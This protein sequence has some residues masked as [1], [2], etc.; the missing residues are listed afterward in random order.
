MAASS[1]RGKATRSS[2][3][4]GKKRTGKASKPIVSLS[5][6][7]RELDARHRLGFNDRPTDVAL[8]RSLAS[9]LDRQRK[10]GD[11]INANLVRQ[12][13]DALESLRESELTRPHDDDGPTDGTD[14]DADD[15]D[16]DGPAAA[17]V[18]L[19]RWRVQGAASLGDAFAAVAPVEPPAVS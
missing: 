10:A 18:G 17:V 4:D 8:C 12:Y 13:R 7:D 16:G 1:S 19:D 14:A 11:G 3:A 2:R 5:A 15:R 6:L 9:E